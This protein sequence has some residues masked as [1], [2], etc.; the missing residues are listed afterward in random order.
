M[1]VVR[2]IARLNVGGP[3]RH[4]TWLT[5]ALN[6]RGLESVLVAGTV[7]PGEGD[8]TYFARAHGVEP[9]IIPEMSREISWKDALT[10]WKLYRLLVR[11]RPDIVHTH[12]AKAGTAGR[13][14]GLLYRWLVP[15]A[16]FLRPR[17]CR[18]VHTYHGHIF[19]SYYGALKSGLF[20]LIEK[21][22]ARTATD[23]IIV[24]S[25]QQYGE[26]HE[27][28]GVG[29]ASQFSCIPLGLDLEAFAGWTARRRVLRDEIG[30]RDE[31]VLV[32][33]VGRLTEIKNHKLF[34]EAAARY[35]KE[36]AATEDAAAAKDAAAARRR[37]RFL[38]IGD[39]HLSGALEEEAERLGL[40]ADV[41]FMGQRD[42]AENFY[43]GLDIVALTS[44]NE[45][46]PLTLI[47]AMAN[48]RAVVSV[49]VG[50]VVDLVGDE[51]GAMSTLG[52]EKSAMSARPPLF[53]GGE[54]YAVCERGVLVRPH[55]AEAFGKA[56]A[57]IVEDEG[58]RRELGERGR[59]FVE[60]H[61]S[62][63]RLIGDVRKLYEELLPRAS[64]AQP[65]FITA[66]AAYKR[67]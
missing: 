65:G 50:G 56:L 26:I 34:L 51:R 1:K 48:E 39:G 46:T 8:M 63:E 55:D 41:V 6:D 5:A 29:R 66:G 20:L 42:D 21:A 18:F 60:S 10:V 35:M 54:E 24:I 23:S 47:E 36:R 31:D 58:L 25:P 11:L 30:A 15:S 61:Y 28:F 9:V 32:G 12:T 3:A 22:L 27:R 59:R 38:V 4:V 14:A 45:G 40:G 49:A 43:P 57:A 62:K 13:L 53:A 52:D 37:V 44:L 19:H 7:P 17:P 33:I 2:I 67:D 16:L 64:G